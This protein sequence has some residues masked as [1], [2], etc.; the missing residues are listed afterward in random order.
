MKASDRWTLQGIGVLTVTKQVTAAREG[1]YA[2]KH[3]SSL[4]QAELERS[5]VA[6]QCL[7]TR[8]IVARLR[9]HYAAGGVGRHVN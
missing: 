5:L 2:P 3:G 7:G 8:R 4:N 6:R 1:Q 9:E